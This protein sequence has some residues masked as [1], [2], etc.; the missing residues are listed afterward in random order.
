MKRIESLT[1]I[2]FIAALIVVVFH[3]GENT[4]IVKHASPFIVSGPQMVSL[5]FVLSGF[6]MIVAHYD[7]SNETFTSY[8]MKRIARIVPVYVLAL[9]P[10]YFFSQAKNKIPALLLSLTFVQ[11]W[12]PPYPLALNSPAW[13]LSVEAFF[14][15][16]F[17]LALLGIRKGGISWKSMMALSFLLYCFTQAILSNLLGAEFYRGFPSP[18]HD[19]IHYFPLAHYCS[20]LL[21]IS[22]GLLYLKRPDWF[23]RDGFLPFAMLISTAVL[24]YFA[25]QKPNIISRIAGFPPAYESSFYSFLFLLLILSLAHSRNIVTKIMSTSFFVLLGESSYSLYI[26]QKPVHYIYAKYISGHLAIGDPD[27]D[28]YVFIFLLVCAAI[29]SYYSIEKPGKRLI[30]GIYDY[31]K[32]RGGRKDV[33]QPTRTI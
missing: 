16:T 19:L 18:S 27:V 28:F 22:G 1:V 29:A 24:T 32:K 20:F 21:G 6:V 13:S 9:I 23:N 10:I 33:L 25:L 8:Y 30:L 2:R 12:F 15:L 4:E 31:A 17:P 3:Y 26:L 14:Y 7:K 5:F 11:S